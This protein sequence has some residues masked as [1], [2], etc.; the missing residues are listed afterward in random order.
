MFG[1]W[2]QT[3]RAHD[4]L[5]GS[6][7]S[8]YYLSHRDVVEGS[9]Q[10]RI[11]IRDVVS[12]RPMD[13]TAQHATVDYEVDYLA[14]RIIMREPLSSVA[15]AP[16]LVRSG[17]LDGDNAYL[18]VDYE[19]LVDG[20]I[21]DGTLGARATQ[22]LGP[23]RLGGTVV[24]EFRAGG[25]YTLL[26]G[27]VQID[28]K[29]WGVILGEY[30]HSYGALTSFSRSDDGGLTYTDALG[31]SQASAGDARRA[32]PR[33]PRPI[34]T[35]R[36]GRPASLFRAAST[37]ATPT[38][39]TPQDAGFM[40]WG[41]DADA[42]LL[43]RASCARTTTSGAISRRWSTTPPA[44]RSRR[45]VTETRATSAARSAR[46]FGASSACG[47]ARAPSAPTTPTPARAGHRTA[48]G[49]RVDVRVVPR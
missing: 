16:T 29:S 33:R 8:L 20:D 34:C 3:A 36:A 10:V 42:A 7:G 12:D 48:V 39:R 23:V 46:T 6:G 1:A 25:N 44:R 43:R 24:N 5:R 21:D 26:G 17:N 37:R 2:L 14:G 19:Y 11:E 47:S 15:P 35:T 38:P 30:A 41:A 13:N 22:K 27:D 28:L 18:V 49:A 9:E 45:S 4:E 31:S 32:T 40:Q